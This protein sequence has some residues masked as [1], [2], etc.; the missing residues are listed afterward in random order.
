MKQKEMERRVTR[1]TE[2]VNVAKINKNK[3]LIDQVRTKSLN[4]SLYSM[5][6]RAEMARTNITTIL[7]LNNRTL[8][9]QG[10]KP[11]TNSNQSTTTAPSAK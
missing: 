8:Q 11:Q 3:I 9:I 5:I 2:I 7:R 1:R 6:T 4:L 10:P